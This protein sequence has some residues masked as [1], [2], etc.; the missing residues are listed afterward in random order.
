MQG[1]ANLLQQQQRGA[2]SAASTSSSSSTQPRASSSPADI[3]Q[4]ADHMWKFLDEL[5]ESDPDAYKKFIAQQMAEMEEE[6]KKRAETEAM[7]T[8]QP[9]FAIVTQQVQPQPSREVFINLCTSNAVPPLQTKDHKPARGDEPLQDILVP[10]S[11]GRI[12]QQPHGGKDVWTSDIVFNPKVMERA[13]REMGFKLF[14]LELSM[15]HLEEDEKIRL[16]RGY[17]F[18]PANQ[19]YIGGNGRPAQQKTE[20]E[21]AREKVLQQMRA[22]REE[23]LKKLH[24]PSTGHIVM[25]S[26]AKRH[27][28]E[29][30]YEEQAI[31][32]LKLR[33]NEESGSSTGG[34]AKKR[35]LIE[36]LTPGE[37][38]DAPLNTS[39]TPSAA[40]T[41]TQDKPLIALASTTKSSA[42]G[43]HTAANPS[44]SSPSH[45]APKQA[46]T[47]F[48]TLEPS[49]SIKP[50]S[51][52]VSSDEL[53]SSL[54]AM[55]LQDDSN[56]WPYGSRNAAI[57]TQ[58]TPA[59][60]AAASAKQAQAK[61]T[62]PTLTKKATPT[63]TMST[64]N[65]R[66]LINIHLPLV[67]SV[68]DVEV[69]VS[70]HQLRLESQQYQLTVDFPQPIDDHASEA[71]FVKNT[72]MLKIA[73]PIAQ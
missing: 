12:Q 72:S 63:H 49:S 53:L 5:A 31:K 61:A 34:Q 21:L 16:H 54:A 46:T 52:F 9:A 26:L 69:D 40:A 60:T 6:K 50:S 36:D 58:P 2:A 8:P 62:T 57:N 38:E 3:R 64:S 56:P 68:R 67:S 25:P 27:E 47:S 66:M 43:K 59:A 17:K 48:S 65:G 55:P 33:A 51:A 28:A 71:K 7:F 20:S 35:V 45:A 70:R 30:Q 39:S 23:K 11:V 13:H 32:E 73:A 41:P 18:L 29:R 19:P 22:E 44:S 37:S 1:L 14:L 42:N 10:I 4:H 15:Q 24:T